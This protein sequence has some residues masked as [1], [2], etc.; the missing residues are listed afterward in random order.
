LGFK[1]FDEIE[2]DIEE[3]SSL[4]LDPLS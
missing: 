1:R 3:F 4:G 2:V